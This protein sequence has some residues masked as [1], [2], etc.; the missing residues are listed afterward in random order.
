MKFCMVLQDEDFLA[1]IQQDR[2]PFIDFETKPVLAQLTDLISIGALGN[3][4]PKFLM[5]IP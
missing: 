1:K 2:L 5:D 4:M 3:L